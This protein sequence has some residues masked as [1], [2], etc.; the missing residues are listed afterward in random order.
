M[1]NKVVLVTGGSR[2][3]GKAIVSL[4]KKE[5]YSVLSPTRDKLN[6]FDNSSIEKYIKQNK[7]IKIDIII[8]NA[9][10]NHPQWIDEMTDDNIKNTIQINL[11]AP[12]RL[13][14]GFVT[15]MKKNKWGRIINMSSAFGIVARGKQTLYS[16][17]K[18]GI[19]GL[20]KALALELAEYNILV[21]SV[22]PGFAATEM[23]LRNPP[24]KVKMIEKDIP[25]GRLVKPIEIARL[26]KFLISEDN[27]YIT[28]SNIIIDGGFTSK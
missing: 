1:K 19:N 3:I 27:T 9:G 26:V 21:N 22:C 11:E 12:I 24:E 4:L 17:T 28:G 23:V 15:N 20:T 7:D 6:L 8:N 25:L 10:I 5:G 13:I 14:R 2:G 18:H 16:S